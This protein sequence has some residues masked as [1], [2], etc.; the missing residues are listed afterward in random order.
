MANMLLANPRKR[1]RRTPK[2]KSPARRRTTSLTTTKKVTRRYKRNPSGRMGNIM[3]TTMSTT[4]KGAIGAAGALGVDIVLNKIPQLANIGTPGMRPL[5]EGG[6]GIALGMIVG[7][8]GKKPALGRDLAEGALTVAL[9]K[10]GKELVGPS[11]G[12]ADG[13][14]LD[15]EL[16]DGDFDDMGYISPAP[17]SSMGD[18]E[19][20]DDDDDDYFD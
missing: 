20:F 6:V 15:G 9:Y 3:Q 1:K 11:V 2:R 19:D 18:L 4:K 16:L 10:T 17:V 14:L 12:L 13:E 8:L 5:I 7:K